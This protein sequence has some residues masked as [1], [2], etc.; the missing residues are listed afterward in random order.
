MPE[1]FIYGDVDR[2]NTCQGDKVIY[3]TSPDRGNANNHLTMYYVVEVLKFTN[4]R[5]LIKHSW[6]H[7]SYVKNWHLFKLSY[8]RGEAQLFRPPGL[9]KD[10]KII[11]QSVQVRR[12]ENRSYYV[13]AFSTDSL[14]YIILDEFEG[15]GKL[16]MAKELQK[17][18]LNPHDLNDKCE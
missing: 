12:G 5:V 6:G 3:V 18:I 14:G 1:Q 4:E 7:E 15:V 16:K 11:P 10:I 13:E 17:S 9:D 2:E 8:M